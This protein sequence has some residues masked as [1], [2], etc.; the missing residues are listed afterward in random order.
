MANRLYINDGCIQTEVSVLLWKT[1]LGHFSLHHHK[2]IRKNST[3]V[4]NEF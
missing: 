3:Q 1:P 2:L 4:I